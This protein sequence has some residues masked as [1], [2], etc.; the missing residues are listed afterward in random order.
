M[1]IRAPV[2]LH[3]VW[4]PMTVSQGRQE[5]RTEEEQKK[6]R[7]E[8]IDAI[9]R[10]FD[11]ARAFWKARRAEGRPIPME[12]RHTRLFEKYDSKPRGPH[13]RPR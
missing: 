13:A 11:E 5:R 3:V 6:A 2:G 8:A 10:C 1:T 12:S 9:G 7:D 4:P